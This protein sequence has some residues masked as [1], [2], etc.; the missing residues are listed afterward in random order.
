MHIVAAG[1][2][3]RPPLSHYSPVPAD[4]AA[5]D[6]VLARL[7]GEVH[8]VA[9]GRHDQQ[10]RRSKRHP[11]RARHGCN[12]KVKCTMSPPGASSTGAGKGGDYGDGVEAGDTRC[13]LRG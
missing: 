7:Q 10:Q 13:S 11:G 3:A 4:K 5:S 1:G 8:E 9:A 2:G 6:A 12:Q